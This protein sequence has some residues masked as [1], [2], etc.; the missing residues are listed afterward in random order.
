MLRDEAVALIAF[1]LGDRHD[2][3]DQIIRELIAQQT[4]LELGP[5]M[6]WFLL[7]EMATAQAYEGQEMV[8]LPPDFLREAEEESALWWYDSTV[9]NDAGWTEIFKGGYDYIKLKYPG[10]GTPTHY[11]VTGNC[12]RLR[13]VPDRDMV[14]KMLYY[15]KDVEL[16]SN[17]ANRWL[18]YA[19]L[20][21]IGEAGAAIAASVSNQTAMAIFAGEAKQARDA[22][23]IQNTAREEANRNRSMGEAP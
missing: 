13:P 4:K 21:L 1:R 7:T 15:A 20:L 12:I 19:P 3:N 6:P 17:V 18:Q 9:E 5:T 10:I 22:L 2:L 16:S 14:L 11:A 8:G 23:V